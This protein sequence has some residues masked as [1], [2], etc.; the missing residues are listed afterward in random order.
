MTQVSTYRAK[1]KTIGLVFLFK[2]D[3]NGHLR[4]FEIAEGQLNDEQVGWLFSINFPATEAVMQKVWMKLPKYTKVFV[5]ERSAA[6]IS[7]DALWELYDH[8]VKRVSAEKAFNKLNEAD[9]IKCFIAI[10]GYLL[11]LTRKRTGKAMLATFINQRYF[12]DEWHK[13]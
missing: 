8:K 2:Y 11:Y 1:G 4:G 12:E 13:A 7:F 9:R 3:L 6:D 5:V 10:P